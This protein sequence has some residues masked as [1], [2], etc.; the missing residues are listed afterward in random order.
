[1]KKI[2]LFLFISAFISS[3]GFAQDSTAHSKN[4]ATKKQ[5]KYQQL[6]L[7][8]EQQQK[9]KQI[10]QDEKIKRAAIESN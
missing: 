8:K 7:T 2:L 1:M 10:K 5:D 4:A 3:A 9:M 6:G